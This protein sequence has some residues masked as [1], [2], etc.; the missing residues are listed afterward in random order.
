MLR[1]FEDLM[2]ARLIIL[3]IHKPCIII[4]LGL[5]MTKDEANSEYTK[6]N[7]APTGLYT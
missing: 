6:S 4:S 3:E 1:F 7:V 5:P 2:Y